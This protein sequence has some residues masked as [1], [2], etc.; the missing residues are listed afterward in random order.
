MYIGQSPGIVFP[1][2]W[3][4]PCTIITLRVNEFR[5]VACARLY[6]EA[7]GLLFCSMEQRGQVSHAEVNEVESSMKRAG[8]M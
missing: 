5:S 4:W 3:I 2:N 1:S 6:N 7:I 8:E